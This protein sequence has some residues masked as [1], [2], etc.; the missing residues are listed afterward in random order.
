[1]KSRISGAK[2]IASLAAFPILIIGIV[3]AF[4]VFRE[5][6]WSVFST[7]EKLKGWVAQWGAAGPIVFLGL[8]ALQVIVFVI[9]GEVP[10]IAGGYLFGI[11][12][13]LILSAIGIAIGS[14]VSFFLA[15]LLGVPFVHVL[16][17]PE[18]VQR[19]EKLAASPRS[20][21]AL[22]LLFLIPGI[23]KD[24]LCYVAGL[25]PMRFLVFFVISLSGRMPGILGSVIMGN[26]AAEQ[27]WVF[28]AIVLSISVVFFVI[29]LLFRVKIES[30]IE[31]ISSRM[32]KH[33]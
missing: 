7:P 21:M 9:P 33:Q 12:G 30:W 28:A 22:F 14:C 13:G 19:I 17:P 3:V 31:T 4:L 23:P 15:R 29:G 25:A 5:T 6:L 11:L 1:M 18:Q 32:R 16:F 27:N 26:A 8:Q 2:R 24:I 20:T 10:Q